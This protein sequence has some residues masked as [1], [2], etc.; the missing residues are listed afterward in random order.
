MTEEITSLKTLAR[1]PSSHQQ[2]V[3]RGACRLCWDFPR[4]KPRSDSTAS[5]S[6]MSRGERSAD[7]TLAPWG[8]FV[9]SPPIP[10]RGFLCL[11]RLSQPRWVAAGICRGGRLERSCV[12]G[13]RAGR[14]P[15]PRGDSSAGRLLLGGIPPLAGWTSSDSSQGA[16]DVPLIAQPGAE[17]SLTPWPPLQLPHVCRGT[18]RASAGPHQ[19]PNPPPLRF[20]IRLGCRLPCRGRGTT[21]LS[22]TASSLPP[23][24]YDSQ[25]R[26]LA[27]WTPT[28]ALSHSYLST[29]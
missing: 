13:G 6:R 27:H 22:P 15:R 11:G 12:R 7:Q 2:Q 28:G 29:I 10:L 8:P 20:Q 21:E 23:L 17:L 26:R 19:P 4:K 1:L 5:P 25:P 16:E 18:N 3:E 9:P 14:Q 24:P